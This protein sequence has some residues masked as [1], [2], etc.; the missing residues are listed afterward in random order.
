MFKL[1]GYS[2]SKITE[3]LINT[4]Y[5]QHYSNYKLS[6]QYITTNLYKNEYFD[7][8]QCDFCSNDKSIKN[9]FVQF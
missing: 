6:E 5:G 7:I 4:G 8:V 1:L 2:D 9:C 3:L